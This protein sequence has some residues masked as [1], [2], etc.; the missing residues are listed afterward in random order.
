MPVE[1]LESSVPSRV[2]VLV[3]TP[4]VDVSAS[5][6]VVALVSGPEVSSAD[7]GA[8][9]EHARSS[10]KAET[11]FIRVALRRTHGSPRELAVVVPAGSA[12]TVELASIHV[13]GGK[14]RTKSK[15]A[16]HPCRTAKD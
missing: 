11:R 6:V 3:S 16:S 9:G 12:A 7:F 13:V 1:V 14:P 5:D 10:A 15:A 4:V 2:V 8:L